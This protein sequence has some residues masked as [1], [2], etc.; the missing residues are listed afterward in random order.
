[1]LYETKLLLSNAV[2]LSLNF[3]SPI[4]QLFNSIN[5]LQRTEKNSFYGISEQE[6]DLRLLNI[7]ESIVPV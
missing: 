7:Y 5:I 4:K 1:M 6:I 3:I 2:M